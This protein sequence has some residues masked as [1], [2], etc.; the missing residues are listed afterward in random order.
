MIVEM[1]TVGELGTNCFIVVCE[2]TRKAVIID[3][4]GEAR[5]ILNAAKRLQAD[6]QYIVN[7]HGH[8]DHTLADDEIKKATGAKLA[9]HP[10]EAPV[11]KSS[12][13]G[14]ATWLRIKLPESQPDLYLNEGD[15]LKVGNI[16]FKVLHTPGHSPGHITLLTDGKAFVGD[17]LFYQGIGRTDLPG[18]SYEQLMESIRNKLLSLGDDTV[19]YPGHGPITTVGQERRHN[20]W[21]VM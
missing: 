21:L 8:F 1:L 9:I 16:A 12:L 19:V 20:P 11:L 3:P 7:T 13:Q 4:G 14:M 5:L 6:V 15:E 18:G 17:C 2:E 10:L